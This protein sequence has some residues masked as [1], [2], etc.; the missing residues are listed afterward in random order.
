M[1]ANGRACCCAVFHC[2]S[3]PEPLLNKNVFGQKIGF[4]RTRISQQSFDAAKIIFDLAK[5]LTHE[6]FFIA[7]KLALEDVEA[8]LTLV[9]Q[10]VQQLDNQDYYS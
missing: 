5:G 7:M 3:S 10:P 1:T 4:D 6:E 2:S 9:S 8:N